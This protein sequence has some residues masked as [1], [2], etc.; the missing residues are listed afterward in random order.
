M[1]VQKALEWP[2]QAS[3]KQN[4][5]RPNVDNGLQFCQR[6]ADI[7]A[8]DEARQLNSPRCPLTQSCPMQSMKLTSTTSGWV[9][10][11][12]VHSLFTVMSFKTFLLWNT[13]EDILKNALGQFTHKAS[14]IWDVKFRNGFIKKT[15]YCKQKLATLAT[16]LG[17]SIWATILELTL[18]RG[19]AC[20]SWN[21]FNLTQHLQNVAI[22][23]EHCKDTTVTHVH[24]VHV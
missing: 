15:C 3:L 9:V 8:G 17:S 16:P 4:R 6:T 5:S 1:N 20:K 14:K 2:Q 10:F 12:Q 21:Y 13:K 22:M 19:A 24:L 23:C 7:T 11:T 18:M